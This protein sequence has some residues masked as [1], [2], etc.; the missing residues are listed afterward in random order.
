MKGEVL[1]DKGVRQ[2]GRGML[3]GVEGEKV[4]PGI[5]RRFCDQGGN[6]G[7]GARLPYDEFVLR[8]KLRAA[9]ERVPVK[10][11]S[12]R[13]KILTPPAIVAFR[14]V[15]GRLTALVRGRDGMLKRHNSGRAR[16][17]VAYSCE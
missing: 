1:I 2:K 8:A 4:F 12:L 11:R 10:P 13:L 17:R 3:D 7:Q 5:E 9:E 14:D 16:V 6:A 15:F